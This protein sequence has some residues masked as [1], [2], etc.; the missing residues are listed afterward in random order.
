[1]DTLYEIFVWSNFAWPIPALIGNI[2]LFIIY[3]RSNLRQSSISIYFRFSLI[4]ETSYALWFLFDYAAFIFFEKDFLVIF[5][6][7][8]RYFMSNCPAIDAWIQVLISL[9]RFVNIA[10]PRRFPIFTSKSFQTAL[11]LALIAYNLIFYSPIIWNTY[12]AFPNAP[13][14]GWFDSNGTQLFHTYNET[15]CNIN[16]YYNPVFT[17]LDLFNSVIVP[18]SLMI[19][20][21]A[22]LIASLIRTRS[23]V[24]PRGPNNICTNSLISNVSSLNKRDRKFAFTILAMNFFFLAMNLPIL[25]FDAI[26][27]NTNGNIIST[28]II[29]ISVTLARSH[30]GTSFYIQVAINSLVRSEFLKLIRLRSTH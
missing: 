14:I 18:F 25:L 27:F 13:E 19:L 4:V 3:S 29:L 23:R 12:Q 15:F 24:Q 8:S 28:I 10:F 17:K 5:C 7:F 6:P 1:M 9:D 11:T 20:L 22:M 30:L 26:S 21:S 2:I 16:G